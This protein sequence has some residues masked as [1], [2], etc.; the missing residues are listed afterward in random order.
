MYRKHR[1]LTRAAALQ[2]LADC[3]SQ[4]IHGPSCT[5]GHL[6]HTI[7]PILR[8]QNLSCS[9]PTFLSQQ[10][11]QQTSSKQLSQSSYTISN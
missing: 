2:S 9:S 4:G 3:V 6:W 1:A 10:Q 8:P 7:T 11:Q 5:I